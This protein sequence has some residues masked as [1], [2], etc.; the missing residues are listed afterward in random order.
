MLYLFLESQACIEYMAANIAG[1]TI[2]VRWSWV[3]IGVWVVIGNV[4]SSVVVI[5]IQLIT[6]IM[7]TSLLCL[8]M[9]VHYSCP[10]PV[11]WL[12]VTA[13]GQWILTRGRIAGG[14]DFSTGKFN[15][16]LEWLDCFCGWPVGTLVD[17]MWVILESGQLGMVLG[18][19]RGNPDVSPSKVSV[20]V[21]DLDPLL[22]RSSLGASKSISQTASGLVQPILQDSL[23]TDH[24][25]PICSN[26]P[27]LHSALMW[28]KTCWIESLSLMIATSQPPSLF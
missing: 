11:R 28:P 10:Q 23:Q 24:I 12:T 3:H 1:S 7:F 9:F 14:G 13:S 6:A 25:T 26:R 8:C 17:S 27:H 21:G 20:P 15:V 18:S 19:M 2:C 5:I 22:I 16:T 4:Y